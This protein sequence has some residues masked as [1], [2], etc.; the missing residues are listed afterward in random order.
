MTTSYDLKAQA[1]AYRREA[2]R[3]DYAARRDA[4]RAAS[5]YQIAKA[6]RRQL[7]WVTGRPSLIAE[8]HTP[9]GLDREVKTWTHVADLFLD[10][11]FRATARARF[12][13]SLARDYDRMA[14]QRAASYATA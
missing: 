3:D 13:R 9:E 8:D 6:V 7:A 11:S 14:A 10:S 12:H 1:N 4:K 2:K 5:Y